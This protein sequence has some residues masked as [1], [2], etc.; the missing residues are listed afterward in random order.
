MRQKAFFLRW[1]HLLY[2][3]ILYVFGKDNL[4]HL[5]MTVTTDTKICHI[6][7]WQKVYKIACTCGK[8]WYDKL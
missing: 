2:H 5:A 7:V 8:T 6:V 1:C 3:N 4:V